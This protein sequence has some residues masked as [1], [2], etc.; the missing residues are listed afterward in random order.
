MFDTIKTD[1][2]CKIFF[3]SFLGAQ[4]GG[5]VT[6]SVCILITLCLLTEK[7]DGTILVF[8]LSFDLGQI[9]IQDLVQII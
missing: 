8:A 5:T 9:L 2:L 3:F 4:R 6:M 7:S 1:T